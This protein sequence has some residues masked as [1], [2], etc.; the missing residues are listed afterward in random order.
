M[1]EAMLAAALRLPR[2]EPGQHHGQPVAVRLRRAGHSSTF[3]EQLLQA[4][5]T[6]K[7]RLCLKPT[8]SVDAKGSLLA[9]LIANLALA[10]LFCAGTAV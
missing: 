8:F 2:F 9:L 1:D 3:G 10:S 5:S 4:I 6:V 7:K